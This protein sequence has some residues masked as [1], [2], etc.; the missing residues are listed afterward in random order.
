MGLP[1]ISGAGQ[2]PGPCR[3]FKGEKLNEGVQDS[4]SFRKVLV[5]GHISEGKRCVDLIPIG[6]GHGGSG[7]TPGTHNQSSEMPSLWPQQH[8]IGKEDVAV[9]HQLF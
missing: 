9:S 3:R 6:G 4:C 2:E 5:L 7:T 8:P 1:E